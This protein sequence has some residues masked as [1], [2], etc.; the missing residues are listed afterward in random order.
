MFG[1]IKPLPGELLVRQY[2]YY[3]AAYCGLCRASGFIGR[4]GLAYDFVFLELF[5]LALTGETPD[6]KR[7]R[8]AV[9]PLRKRPYLAGSAGAQTS[10]AARNA[11]AAAAV[12][13]VAKLRDD[14][15]DEKGAAQIAA[16]L[17][18]AAAKARLSG[19]KRRMAKAAAA[20]AAVPDL[21]A[22]E[23]DVTAALERLRETEAANAVKAA[24]LE[25]YA[26]RGAGKPRGGINMSRDNGG[27]DG[28]DISLD[29]A[30][31]AFGDALA[32][33]FAFG[34][35][36]AA[37]RIAAEAGRHAGRW[38][39]VIDALDDLR[40]DVAARRYNALA[41][42]YGAS[43]AREALAEAFDGAALELAAL[44][45]AAEL[46]PADAPDA[47]AC[48]IN[49]ICSGMPAAAAAVSAK[50]SDAAAAAQ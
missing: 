6:L 50:L 36:G 27:S 9:H 38:L 11:A 2:E 8:C 5:W 18:F 4:L 29:D 31:D 12:L 40:A 43:P 32:A 46:L 42:V 28:A 14:I 7:A 33:V 22:L 30:A 45:A 35:D 20:G 37:R 39:Y 3:R 16:S 17:K 10:A 13:A 19:E 1:Y 48:V 26:V 34:L 21:D 15:E 41:V 25:I 23:R 24:R 49:V 44:H 47:R